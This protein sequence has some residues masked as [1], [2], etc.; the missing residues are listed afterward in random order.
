MKNKDILAN[1]PLPV[2][3]VTEMTMEEALF[4]ISSKSDNRTKSGILSGAV[5][6]QYYQRNSAAQRQH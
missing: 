2:Y 3:E 4:A 5:L 6:H 1:G